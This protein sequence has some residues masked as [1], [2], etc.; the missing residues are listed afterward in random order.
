MGFVG[1]LGFDQFLGISD[2]FWFIL[3]LN[4]GLFVVVVILL[5]LTYSSYP[6]CPIHHCELQYNLSLDAY[7]CKL[8]S[9]FVQS[10]EQLKR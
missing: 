5:R 2:L 3:A 8:C 1:T 6:A 7:Y 4:V 9:G 10:P